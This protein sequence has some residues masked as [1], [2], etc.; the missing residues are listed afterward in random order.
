MRRA[1]PYLTSIAL[2]CLLSSFAMAKAESTQICR[3]GVQLVAVNNHLPQATILASPRSA[4]QPFQI[5]SPVQRHTFLDEFYAHDLERYAPASAVPKR[6][7]WAEQRAR[8]FLFP[9]AAKK[10]AFNFFRR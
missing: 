1:A 9:G 8:L 7:I 5:L 2:L 10:L 3:S 4:A 6:S